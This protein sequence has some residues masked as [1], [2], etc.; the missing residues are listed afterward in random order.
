V[1]APSTRK[2]TA[3]FC[4]TGPRA[5]RHTLATCQ[6]ISTSPALGIVEDAH[7]GALVVIGSFDDE[8]TSVICTGHRY[9][10]SYP[11]PRSIVVVA[12]S[13]VDGYHP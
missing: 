7:G 12:P 8:P 2:A 1:P 6:S 3:T 9:E 4:S 10:R 13:N 11:V 5:R